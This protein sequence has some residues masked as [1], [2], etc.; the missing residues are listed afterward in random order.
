MHYHLAQLNVAQLLQPIDHPDTR[1]F[2]D[3]LS[4]INALAET[5]EGFIWRLKDA[6]EA[7]QPPVFP[8]EPTIISTL[9]VWTSPELLKNYVYKTEHGTFFKRRKAWF[10][11]QTVANYVLWW[12]PVGHHPTNAKAR[13]RLLHLRQHGETEFAFSFRQ[14]IYPQE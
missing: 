3:N 12:I 4:R 11:P 1:E 13:E 14:I 5:S 7:A 6:E 2:K 10:A 9:S 8:E